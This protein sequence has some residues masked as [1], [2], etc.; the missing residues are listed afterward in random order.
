MIDWIQQL[1]LKLHN[2]ALTSNQMEITT[3]A[4]SKHPTCSHLRVNSKNREVWEEDLTCNAA[5]ETF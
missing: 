1:K 5:Q 4:G 3:E 2:A